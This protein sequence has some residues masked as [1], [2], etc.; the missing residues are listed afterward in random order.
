M[1]KLYTLPPA[2]HFRSLKIQF[3][4]ALTGHKLE[5]LN[6][7]P[8]FVF[9]ETNKTPEFLAKFPMG[10][11]PALETKK[12]EA[13]FES[14]AIAYYVADE[15]L[16][17]KHVID[18]AQVQQWINFAD[19]E[20]LP[21]A[22]TWVFPTMG[23]TQFNKAETEAAKEHLKKCLDVLNVY[24]TSRTFLVGERMTLADIV[25]SCNMR[26]LFTDVMDPE[27]RAP[28]PNVIRW[29]E[30]IVNHP[31]FLKLVKETKMCMKAAQPDPKKYAEIHGKG[32]GGGKKEEKKE[33]KSPQGK[34]GG[35]KEQEE[36][37]GDVPQ[38]KAVDPLA[39]LPKGTFDMD[40]FKRAYSNEDTESVA[41]PLFW[42]TFDKEHY[43]IYTCEYTDKESL[44][45]KKPYMSKNLVKGMLQRVEKLRKHALGIMYVLGDDKEHTVEG[46]WIFKGHE[47]A[48][49]LCDDWNVDAPSYTFKKM[50]V[51]NP[52]DKEKIDSLILAETVG[53]ATFPHEDLLQA[54][55]C[56][57]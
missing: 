8:D 12:G 30:T 51:D 55:E 37:A 46:L 2:D 6:K 43:S 53:S 17:G 52:A 9:G 48:F 14:N 23:I 26:M 28:Y 15:Q 16:R 39:A 20:I 3:A 50:D 42:K 38:E 10:K 49:G 33:A 27:F 44:K 22:C 7:E 1:D 57:K 36:S 25:L 56:L 41:I 18:A 13:V 21:S 34:K 54:Y 4:A 11:V 32:K 31:E 47:I 40:A 35:G 24:L 45:G 19:N 5:V 29:F